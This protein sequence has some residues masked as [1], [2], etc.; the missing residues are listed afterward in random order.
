M[1]G[2]APVTSIKAC[3]PSK[4]PKNRTPGHVLSNNGLCL[5]SSMCYYF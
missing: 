5:S 3:S 1:G 2:E 4:V